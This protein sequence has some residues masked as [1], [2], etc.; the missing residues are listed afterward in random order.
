VA[1]AVVLIAARRRYPGVLT[2]WICFVV[3]ALPVLGVAVNHQNV[4][5]DRYTYLSLIPASVLIVGLLDRASRLDSR[6]VRQVVT[7]VTGAVLL[8]LGVLTFRQSTYWKDSIALWN[9]QIEFD[10]ECAVA[11]R[12]RGSALYLL[13]DVRGAL[14]DYDMSLK[15]K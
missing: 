9:R 15:L 12:N 8:A 3:L 7:G 2:V 13:G 4:A 10:P 6:T 14:R 11:Y 1:G 5:A